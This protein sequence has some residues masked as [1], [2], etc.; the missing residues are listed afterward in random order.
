MT[1]REAY[2]NKHPVQPGGNRRPG[3]PSWRLYTWI[4]NA[5]MVKQDTKSDSEIPDRIAQHVINNIRPAVNMHI[6][7]SGATAIT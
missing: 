2:A 6:R 5:C 1:I 7:A 4:I 3:Q